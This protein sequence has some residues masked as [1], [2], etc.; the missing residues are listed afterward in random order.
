MDNLWVKAQPLTEYWRPTVN[1]GAEYERITPILHVFVQFVLSLVG[2]ARIAAAIS[3][4]SA[5]D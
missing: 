5:C 4:S 2:L 1:L 3:N